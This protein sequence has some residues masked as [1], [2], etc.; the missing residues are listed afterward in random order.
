MKWRTW[1]QRLQ[2]VSLCLMACF[3]P[4]DRRL[5]PPVFAIYVLLCVCEGNFKFR[6]QCLIKRRLLPFF[7][8]FAALY[9]CYVTGVLWSHNYNYA[10]L[11]LLLKLPFLLFPLCLF[12][13]DDTIF[14]RKR[15]SGLMYA[16]ILGNLIYA[17]YVLYVWIFKIGVHGI[18]SCFQISG[19]GMVMHHTYISMCFN[20]VVAFIVHI[21]LQKKT[22]VW[23]KVLLVPW[24]F[25]L[26]FEVIALSSRTAWIA[27]ALLLL[28]C[29]VCLTVQIVRRR[30]SPGYLIAFVLLLAGF[31][32]FVRCIPT[33]SNRVLQTF[34][35]VKSAGTLQAADPR[36]TIWECSWD[37]IGEHPIKGVGTGDIRD[38]LTEKQTE[39]GIPSFNSHNQ[40]L[41][42]WVAVGIVGLL[43]FVAILAFSLYGAL[44]RHSF[45][46]LVFLL[47]VVINCMTEAI[48]EKQTGLVF[49]V[50]FDCFFYAVTSLSSGDDDYE[51]ETKLCLM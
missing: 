31:A 28:L 45:L 25:I 46:F 7:M 32:L 21:L 33:A 23:I 17:F 12:T 15:L 35:R 51:T 42:T 30:V 14:T 37:V 41:N 2:Y 44:R 1:I 26:V 39:A 24:V 34:H 6:W 11:D 9:V 43:L 4:L 3:I 47:I 50:F 22:K 29:F 40:F 10:C 36:W 8:L 19:S 13:S 16:F 48:L 49:F 18:W 27:A 20:R 5:F 38:S